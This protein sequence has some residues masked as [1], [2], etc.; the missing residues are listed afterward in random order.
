[1]A[2]KYRQEVAALQAWAPALA[3][4]APQL[5]ARDDA[6]L[7][8]LTTVVDGTPL[9]EL[10]ALDQLGA[11]DHEGRHAVAAYRDLGAFTMRLHSL[12]VAE[13]H[14]VPPAEAYR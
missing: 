9:D 4:H 12:P 1:S 10:D 2:R 11:R 13:D 6:G 3:P 5:L 7:V 8:L 14:P